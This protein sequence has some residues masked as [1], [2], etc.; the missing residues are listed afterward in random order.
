M[1]HETDKIT[2]RDKNEPPTTR[3][4]YKRIVTSLSMQGMYRITM[5]NVQYLDKTR[6][7]GGQGSMSVLNQCIPNLCTVERLLTKEIYRS[8]T[9]KK[10]KNKQKG[11][12]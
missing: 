3:Q 12:E 2:N 7:A 10:E 8:K 5:K 9:V 6:Q 11:T 1:L 4:N